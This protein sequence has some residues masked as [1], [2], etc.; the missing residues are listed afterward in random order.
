MA[1]S[2]ETARKHLDAWLEAELAVING[3]E[4]TIGS[5]TLRRAN[6]ADI[7]AQIKF[8]KSEVQKAEAAE[9]GK[10]GRG[11]IYRVVPRDV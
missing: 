3:Q 11:R 1:I 4:Y 8:W 2:L 9:S 6:L 7:Q 10:G 5:R